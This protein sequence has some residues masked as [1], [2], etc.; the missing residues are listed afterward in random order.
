MARFA[1]RTLGLLAAW[2]LATTADTQAG[3]A[4]PEVWLETWNGPGNHDDHGRYLELDPLGGIYVA[5]TTYQPGT[6]G[7]LDDFVLLRYTLDGTLE[8]SRIHGG[9]LTDELGAVLVT[10]AGNVAVTGYSR[11]GTVTDVATLVYESDGDLLWER[12]FELTGIPWP[13]R[14][15]RMAEDPLGNL[16]ICGESDDDYVILKYASDGTPIWNQTYDGPLSDWDVAS[17]IA[18][19]AAGSVYV[20]GLMNDFGAYG[21]IKLD[22]GGLQWEQIESGESPGIPGA[23]FHM[24]PS[25]SGPTAMPWSSPIPS[26]SAG[27]S[28]FAS[29]SATPQTVTS[30]GRKAIPWIR[31][32][33]SNPWT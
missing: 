20:T 23:S 19:D 27:S 3:S 18:V 15:P 4:P 31:E 2:S 22:S 29:G 8:W 26:R 17:D 16:L 13:N 11:N 9:D 5:G 7:T 25:R 28:V 6:G 1:A 12:R 24:P 30:S 33:R 32:I 10:Q 21:T 14:L